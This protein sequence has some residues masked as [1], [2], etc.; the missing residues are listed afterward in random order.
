MRLPTSYDDLVLSRADLFGGAGGAIL[1]ALSARDQEEE[2]RRYGRT[3]RSTF[4]RVMDTIAQANVAR[5]IGPLYGRGSGR[6][7]DPLGALQDPLS[8][9]GAIGLL[10]RRVFEKYD[11]FV[12]RA[13]EAEAAIPSFLP[14][15]PVRF[16]R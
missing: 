13:T 4:G 10:T 11:A 7:N 14:R 12:P 8:A 15:R 6:E 1:G 2:D 16:R 3:P 5:A 9:S